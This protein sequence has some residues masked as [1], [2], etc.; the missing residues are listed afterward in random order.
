MQWTCHSAW[1][2]IDAHLESNSILF[3]YF[4]FFC[5]FLYCHYSSSF[6]I[7][8]EI[9]TTISAWIFRSFF[10]KYWSHALY[11]STKLIGPRHSDVFMTHCIISIFRLIQLF[12]LNIRNKIKRES[13][14]VFFRLIY[15]KKSYFP[16]GK[17]AFFCRWL[18]ERDF[19]SFSYWTRKYR[20]FLLWVLSD[21]DAEIFLMEDNFSLLFFQWE[22]FFSFGSFSTENLS[23]LIEMLLRSESSLPIRFDSIRWYTSAENLILSSWQF[24]QVHWREMSFYWHAVVEFSSSNI[25]NLRIECRPD[26][27]DLSRVVLFQVW[28]EQLL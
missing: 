11:R 18:S 15:W 13:S 22:F 20:D 19:T 14:Q 21:F 23:S 1:L 26:F 12:K 3:E 7:F 8:D 6:Y 28:L 17:F 5:L 9:H 4:F 27:F 25:Y 24:L 2:N 16:T 10:F